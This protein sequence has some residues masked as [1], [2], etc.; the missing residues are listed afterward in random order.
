[1]ISIRAGAFTGQP[2][3]HPATFGSAF[4]ESDLEAILAAWPQDTEQ[5][6]AQKNEM[7]GVFDSITNTVPDE[8]MVRFFKHYLDQLDQ[9]RKTNWREVLPYLDI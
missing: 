3:L 8:K 9:R 1:M 4:W 6:H 2:Y 7:K 5:D